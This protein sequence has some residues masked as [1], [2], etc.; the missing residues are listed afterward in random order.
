MGVRP[1]E[2][3]QDGSF[4]S[5]SGP[6][7][8]HG[9]NRMRLTL[10]GNIGSARAGGTL[11]LFG[12]AKDAAGNVVAPKGGNR[13]LQGVGTLTLPDNTKLRCDTGT[14]RWTAKQG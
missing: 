10:T 6:I 9:D 13:D 2:D 4:A 12:E 11:R 14:V 1:Y 8:R 5:D 7:H 3:P